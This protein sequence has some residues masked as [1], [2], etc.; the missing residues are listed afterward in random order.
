MEME[1]GEIIL[2]F[3]IRNRTAFVMFNFDSM[4]VVEDRQRRDFIKFLARIPLPLGMGRKRKFS[5]RIG[6]DEYPRRERE[7]CSYLLALPQSLLR[8][9]GVKSSSTMLCG[10]FVYTTL[11]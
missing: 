8:L 9:R 4:P 7:I 1:L 3:V 2:D 10:G 6:A 11:A 5:F